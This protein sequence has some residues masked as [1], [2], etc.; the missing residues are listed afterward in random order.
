MLAP[1]PPACGG[2][3]PHADTV[4]Q[5][6]PDLEEQFCAFAGLIRREGVVKPWPREA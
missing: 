5:W 6:R 2:S 4:R 1:T 3:S